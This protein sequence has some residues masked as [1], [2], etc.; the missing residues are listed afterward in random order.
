M[1]YNFYKIFKE[2]DSGFGKGK[3]YL[4]LQFGKELKMKIECLL[5]LICIVFEFVLC[6]YDGKKIIEEYI[7]QFVN[8]KLIVKCVDEILFVVLCVVLQDF[9]GVLLFVDIVVMCGVVEC[10]GKNLKKIELLVLVDFVVDYLVQIDYFCQ[11]DVFDLN[12]KLE[13]QCNN[14]CYQFMKWGM[15]V[16]DMFKV[17]LLGVGIVY[18]VNF[19]YFVCGVY[20]KVD[21]VDI[22]YYL[23]IFVGMDSYMMMINGIG[24]VGWGVGGIEVEVG[25]FGQLVYFL[26][27]DVVGVELKGKLCE[28]VMVIDLVLMIIEMLCKEK[29]V[30]KFVEFFGE[31][32]KLFLLLDCVMIGNMVLEYGVMMG[33]FL[34]DE[35][36]IDY[37]EGIGCMKVEIVVFENYFKVQKLFGILKVGDIDYMKMVMFD[38]VMVV[39][40][41]VGLKCLQDCI[42]IGYVKLMFIDLFLKL[43][44]ENGFVKKV[45]DLNMQYMMSNGV[46]VKNGDVL[47]VVI[48]LCMNMLNLSVLL[49]VG[50][51]VKKV[52]EV[53]FMVDL[54]IKI[55]FVLGL[56]IVIEYLMKMGLLFY[57]LKFGFEVV[58]YGCMIC[59]GNVGDLMLELNEVIMKNDIVVVV[60]LLGNCNFEVCIYLNIC[61]NFFVLLLF[62]VVYVIVGNIMCDLMIELVGK[63][64]GGCDIYFGDIWL[65]SD[66]IYVLFKFVFDLKKFE[67][68]YLKL[69]KK[70]DFWSKIEGE[71][72]EVYD[73][74]K[75]M[76]IVE[77]L[78]FGN[79]F[80][81]ELVVLILMVKGVCVLGI[82]GDLVMIDYI[83]LVGLIKEDL[84]VGK[85]LKENGVQKVDFNSYGL[86]CGNYDVMMCGM[87]V[88]VWIKNLM[89]LVKVDGMCVEGGLMIYQLSGEQQL[90]Y[91]VVM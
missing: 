83:S 2:F 8:W 9:M 71:M 44:V 58:V 48:M 64:K 85:W 11:K 49:V 34:V 53:G 89:I 39:L 81:M 86:C 33:F 16:F 68:N 78:F 40:L 69:I 74:L 27:L 29:V 51:F 72:G 7:E 54:K 91:D 31:G 43:V 21:G 57:L 30:G 41:L 14:E 63:G 79:D 4:L 17:V 6:N 80:L 55:L 12:M 20:K 10:M 47:I 19:E 13:F 23:D 75:L 38:F 52:V 18:Q 3:F 76:Y 28:G 37:F 32:M 46:D 66:E 73:W 42:E 70:G 24:V 90:I 60:V 62:V 82:F 25:M 59:I 67:D 50:L 65:M 45:E 84:L 88:N 36:M 5:V 61:V 87:F 1:V 56:C 77:L 15:Q 35:K 22:V 26:M